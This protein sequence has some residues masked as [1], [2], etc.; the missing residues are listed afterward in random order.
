MSERTYE[1]RSKKVEWSRDECFQKRWNLKDTEDAPTITNIR[2]YR[3]G[4]PCEGG[5]EMGMME[6]VKSISTVSSVAS[7][8][9]V[10]QD[11]SA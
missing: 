10:S 4:H 2:N 11:T 6:M 3:M 7:P 1:W 9:V 5:A 8:R